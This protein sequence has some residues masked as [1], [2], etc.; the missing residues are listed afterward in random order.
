MPL[1][2]EELTKAV[3]E[4]GILT[5]T[6]DHYTAAGPVA[7]LAIPASLQASLLA[8]LDRLAP[9]REVAQIGAA[10]SRQFSH[11]L[12]A[13]VAPM[14]QRQLDEALARLV[15]AELI[16]RRGTPP[17]AEYSFKH[18]LVQDAA[19]STLLRGRRQQLHA[20][21]AATLEDRFPEI[22]AAQPALL[23]HHCTEA[24]LA[25]KA[26]EYWLA[27]GRQA[28]GRSAIAEAVALLRRGLALVPGL[29]DGDWRREREFDLQIA[30]AQVLV[31]SQGYS[32]S[33]VG[34]A[35][36]RARQLSAALNR[37]RTLLFALF[38][39]WLYH[40]CRA[41]LER[42]RRLAAEMGGLGEASG[43]VPTR[44]M[45]CDARGFTCFNLGEFTEGRTYIEQGLLLYDRA[46]LS[47]AE[48]L[49]YD[50]LVMLRIHSSLLLSYLGYLDQAF[51]QS[52]AALEEARRLSHPHDIAIAL[53]FALIRAWCVGSDPKSLLQRADEHQALATEHGL[54]LHRANAL[55]LRGWCL[56][57]LG[58]AD[59]GIR[60]FRRGLAALQDVGFML[61]RP[62]YLTI[63]ADAC[64]MAGQAQVALEHLAEAHRLA[65]ET[66]NRW[67]LAETLRL[68]GDLL[69]S[70][71][72]P[73]AAETSYGEALALARQQSARLWEL[74]AAMS[75]ARL[76]H[77]QGKPAEARALLAPV[78]GWFTE[79]FGTPVLQEA[80]ALLEEL[81]A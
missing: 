53:G 78:Y 5:D 43:D 11:E 15:S 17:D 39:E 35:Y 2:V 22:V 45:G 30:L 36:A 23:A 74:R 75:L 64:R 1:F 10:L 31:A 65:D 9:V 19:Y 57:A 40:A 13:A 49:P 38:G 33:N 77:D 69:L 67:F 8:R 4:S 63:L 29:P 18:A 21:I 50:L 55:L 20:R 24:G 7:P 60:L 42:A 16:Y 71:G 46:Q 59:E 48:L 44:V 79:G 51:F 32:A 80:K 28:W 58:R 66:Q 14:P 25:E 34:E 68:R 12:I 41:D 62:C 3:V 37:P 54:G 26:V 76:W 70:M 72:D 81:S 52:D 56:A 47:Y 61:H 6:G 27:A 73:A